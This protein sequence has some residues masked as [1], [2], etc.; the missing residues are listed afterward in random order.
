MWVCC[1]WYASFLV[2][3]EGIRKAFKVFDKYNDGKIKVDLLRNVLTRVGEPLSD[4]EMDN[5][6]E[7]MDIKDKEYVE[8]EFL[9]RELASVIYSFLL[10]DKLIRGGRRGRR[11]GGGRR[12]S[13]QFRKLLCHRI[14]LMFM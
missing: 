8:Y 10:T 12:R 9:C 3:E 4:R 1:I 14:F 13:K 11:G 6:L 2:T 7:I 5:F